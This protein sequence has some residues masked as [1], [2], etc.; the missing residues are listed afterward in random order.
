MKLWPGYVK[1]RGEEKAYS[2]FPVI[3][4]Y[5][6]IFVLIKNQSKD[7]LKTFLGE[8]GNKVPL[9]FRL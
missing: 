6:N 9:T 2:I 3:Y 5:R 4:E 8:I 1:N 7:T